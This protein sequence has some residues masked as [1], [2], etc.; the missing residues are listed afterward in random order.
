MMVSR[1]EYPQITLIP[2]DHADELA[3]PPHGGICSQG[4]AILPRHFGRRRNTSSDGQRGSLGDE[5][6][7]ELVQIQVLAESL[8]GLLRV[9][10]L[11][12]GSRS[13]RTWF[14]PIPAV[15]STSMTSSATPT[16]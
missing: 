4:E 3:W 5:A 2:V 14:T 13:R 1:W 11:K 16:A 9:F 8:E 10:E 12:E 15:R 6:I 7:A